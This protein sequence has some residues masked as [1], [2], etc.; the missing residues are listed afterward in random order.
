M[1][2]GQSLFIGSSSKI[3]STAKIS[4]SQRKDLEEQMQ[5]LVRPKPNSNILG[6]RFKLSVYNSV[7]EP[8]KKKGLK[9]WLKYK[10]GEPPVIASNAALE[11]NRQIIQNHLDNKGYFRDSVLKDTSIKNKKLKVTYTALLD[12][13]YKINQASYPND[14]S[15]I[16]KQ[17]QA[18]AINKKEVLLKPNDAYD[19]DVIKNERTRIDA[20]LKEHGYYYFGPDYLIADVDSTVGHYK[21]NINMRVKPET[22]LIARQPYYIKDVY[23][24]THYSINSDTSLIGAKKYQGYTIIDPD[25][26]F[27]PQIFSRTL[28]FKPGDIYNRTDHNFSLNRFVT[29]GVYKFVKVRFE[30]GDSAQ[31]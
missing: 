12:S 30:P 25:N 19:L 2:A 27:K 14:S 21:V 17:I 23:V 5:S 22:P 31:T 15:Q 6:V 29:L 28:V 20:N 8:K 11:K 9:Y 13:Q 16:A 1:A 24:F 10:V 7:K 18:T 26:R 4:K 3:K